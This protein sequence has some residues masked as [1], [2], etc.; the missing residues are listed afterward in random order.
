VTFRQ[1]AYL[2]RSLRVADPDACLD[3]EA[4]LVLR[5]SLQFWTS[6]A[7]RD[8]ALY[9][10]DEEIAELERVEEVVREAS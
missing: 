2:G 7:W 9:A 8:I 5:E 3:Y 1:V 10:I 6:A 4:L